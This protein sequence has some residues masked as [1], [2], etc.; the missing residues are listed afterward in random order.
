MIFQSRY[1]KKRKGTEI[2]MSTPRYRIVAL[3]VLRACFHYLNFWPVLA[4]TPLR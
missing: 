4:L 3:S 2:R 1:K